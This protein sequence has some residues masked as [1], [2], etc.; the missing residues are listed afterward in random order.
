MRAKKAL[1]DVS[2]ET[3]VTFFFLF[4]FFTLVPSSGGTPSE[5]GLRSALSTSIEFEG[6]KALNYKPLLER[7]KPSV[8][9]FSCRSLHK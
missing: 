9:F 2:R 6:A 8:P 1:L 7:S 3:R 5:K 4:F